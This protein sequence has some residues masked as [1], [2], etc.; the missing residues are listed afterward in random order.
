VVATPSGQLHELGAVIVASAAR[1][2]GWR[3]I[4]LGPSLPS[5]EIAGAAL[6][7]R[8]RA[9]AL[10]IVYP[11]DDP[12]LARELDSLKRYLDPEVKILVGGRAAGGYESTLRQMGAQHAD[13]IADVYR[14]LEEWRGLRS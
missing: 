10:S 4:Y 12:S 14:I 8:A 13:E 11:R 6:Q 1:N 9:V 5:A 2:L 7:N 3:V